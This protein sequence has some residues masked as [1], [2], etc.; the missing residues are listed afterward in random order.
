MMFLK[1]NQE[2]SEIIVLIFRLSVAN[3]GNFTP[4]LVTK[5]GVAAH[6]WLSR[7][8]VKSVNN[9]S[10]CELAGHQSAVTFFTF[11][12]T[13]G[14][15]DKVSEVIQSKN[16]FVILFNCIMRTKNYIQSLSFNQEN[17]EQNLQWFVYHIKRR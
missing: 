12:D 7:V 14:L 17:V 6:S 3:Y 9:L 16:V 8:V 5:Y 2:Q 10:C 13:R 4:G 15:C 11:N 1:V